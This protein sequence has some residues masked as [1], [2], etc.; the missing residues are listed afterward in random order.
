MYSEIQHFLEDLEAKE[1]LASAEAFAS[2]NAFADSLEDEDYRAALYGGAGVRLCRAGHYDLA[3]KVTSLAKGP[4]RASQFRQL[5]E[6]LR[7]ANQVQRSLQ[8]YSLVR[9]TV[10][11]ANYSTGIVQELERSAKSLAKLGRRDLAIKFW[12]DAVALAGPKQSAGGHE[13]PESS[14]TLWEAVQGLCELGEIEHAR[15]IAAAIQLDFLKAQAGA[16]IE[17]HGNASKP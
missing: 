10:L 14:G 9:E 13:G 8:M 11:S 6:E 2:L 17:K 15:E 5:A 3:E 16:L 1:S 7:T 12:E 4:E